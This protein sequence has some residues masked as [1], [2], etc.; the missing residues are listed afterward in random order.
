MVDLEKIRIF[1]HVG[2]EGS[3]LAAKKVLN[4][5]SPAISK[6]ITDLENTMKVKLFIRKKKG[7]ILTDDGHRLFAVAKGAV[8]ELEKITQQMQG[9]DEESDVLR[10]ITT[11]GIIGY[12]VLQKLKSVLDKHPSLKLKIYTQDEEVNFSES[13]A[14]VGFLIKVSDPEHVTM[15]KIFKFKLN[16]FASPAYIK[17]KG[18]PTSIDDLKN[19][20]ILSFYHTQHGSVGNVD[21]H[22]KIGETLHVPRITIDSALVQLAAAI[23]G[24]GLFACP[25]DFNIL[26]LFNFIP[27]LENEITIELDAFM[28]Y[29]A[30]KLLD[31]IL[32]EVYQS[33]IT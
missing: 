31:G 5:S 8:S 30:N 16:Y 14:D 6:H 27:V 26:N 23:Q 15:R 28:I 10:I 1:Y 24:Y 12:W 7:M 3:L 20:D 29:P 33:V 13:K 2:I 25:K 32:Q 17:R 9:F 11:P 4:L 19:H 21:W 18:V 22:L